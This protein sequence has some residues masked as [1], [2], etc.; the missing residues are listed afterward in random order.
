MLKVKL[1]G[2]DEAGSMWLLLLVESY[3]ENGL[4]LAQGRIF[5]GLTEPG[6]GSVQLESTTQAGKAYFVCRAYLTATCPPC[7]HLRN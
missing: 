1:E 2:D 6:T 4:H 3:Q 5:F 7:N